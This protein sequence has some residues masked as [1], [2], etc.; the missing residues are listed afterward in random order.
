[1]DEMD[2]MWIP[3]ERAWQ[4]NERHYG[5]LQGLNK[6][7]MAEKYGAEQVHLWRRSYSIPPPPLA[8][9]DPRHPKF[10]KRYAGLKPDEIPACESLELTLE[11]RIT[12]LAC[13]RGA[14][15]QTRK[16][17]SNCSAWEQPACFGKTP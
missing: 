5:A 4:L 9:D 7:E 16:K 17:G 10:D 13:D 1:M 3:V 2:L 8:T 15:T 6:A 12:L 11:A 14:K